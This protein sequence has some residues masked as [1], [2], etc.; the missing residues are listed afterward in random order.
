MFKCLNDISNLFLTL[1]TLWYNRFQI[2]GSISKAID[3]LGGGFFGEG[4]REEVNDDLIK[5]LPLKD[6]EPRV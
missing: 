2:E 6:E 5:N 3:E 4:E 1:L